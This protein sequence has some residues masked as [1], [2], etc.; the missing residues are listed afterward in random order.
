MLR[1][2]DWYLQTFRDNLPVPSSRVKI[3]CPETTVINYQY[4]LRNIP[5]ERR[6]H[7]HRGGSLESRIPFSCSTLSLIYTPYSP[8]KK[9]HVVDTARLN[10]RRIRHGTELNVSPADPS[11]HLATHTHMSQD[12]VKCITHCGNSQLHVPA[13]LLLGNSPTNTVQNLNPSPSFVNRILV[14]YN[15]QRGQ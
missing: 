13:D 2:V 11:K 7:L 6:S 1:R 4:T 12:R 5:E 9:N 3:D 15:C 10:N 8:L 14:P